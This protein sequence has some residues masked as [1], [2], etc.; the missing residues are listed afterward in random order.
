MSVLL[1]RNGLPLLHCCI[2][3]TMTHSYLLFLGLES[4]GF[5]RHLQVPKGLR[6]LPLLVVQ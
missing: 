5:K 4:T 6:F 1:T 3:Y 2:A